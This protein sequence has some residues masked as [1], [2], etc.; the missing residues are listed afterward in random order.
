MI[1]KFAFT[2]PT[3]YRYSEGMS[4]SRTGAGKGPGMAEIASSNQM[5]ARGTEHGFGLN[6]GGGSWGGSARDDDVPEVV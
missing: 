5:L 6:S 3:W 2:N 4:A 1:S